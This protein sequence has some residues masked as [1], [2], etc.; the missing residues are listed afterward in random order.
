VNPWDRNATV[1][2]DMEVFSHFG[3][4][5]PNGT[6]VYH[7]GRVGFAIQSQ[8]FYLPPG[9]EWILE[10][11]WWRPTAV[12]SAIGYVGTDGRPGYMVF[13]PIEVGGSTLCN[14]RE[15]GAI[16]TIRMDVDT[17][18]IKT[19]DSRTMRNGG[20]R[21]EASVIFVGTPGPCLAEDPPV[22]DLRVDGDTFGLNDTVTIDLVL[23]NPTGEWRNVSFDYA[24]PF[25]VALRAP[26]GTTI[27]QTN[28]FAYVARNGTIVTHG[29][30]G[31]T[32]P[33]DGLGFA[34]PPWGE[35]PI[36]RLWWNASTLDIR[37]FEPT[38]KR[39]FFQD[40]LTPRVPG[41]YAIV[42]T[43]N[44]MS[45]WDGAPYDWDATSAPLRVLS[46]EVQ[47]TVAFA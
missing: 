6:R 30:F 29:P 11:R 38:V 43:L 33:A 39:A 16:Y 27:H 24:T 17:M 1:W 42:A 45:L 14:F 35:R 9:G 28:G 32:D 3:I 10:R 5:R 2:F 47:A 4:Y 22:L 7:D 25:A 26:N 36:A 20:W 34:L 8:R 15:D 31:W 46:Q 18:L 41:P 40:V 12:H 44:T 23:V 13:D 19:D 37:R 21:L